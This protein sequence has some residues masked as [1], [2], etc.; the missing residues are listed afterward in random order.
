MIL[1]LVLLVVLLGGLL[2][3]W[4]TKSFDKWQKEGVPHDKPSF[5]NGTHSFLSGKKH[6]NDFALEDYKKFKMEQGH[7]VHGWF[8]MGKPALSINDPELLKQIQVKDFNHFVDRM[9]VNMAKSFLKGG[10]SDKVSDGGEKEIDS[11]SFL[12]YL[13]LNGK[14]QTFPVSL[15]ICTIKHREN[16]EKLS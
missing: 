15:E 12:D 2:Y 9:E 1:E 10:E 4:I 3:R 5:P 7:R 14:V 16:R 8:L 11:E 6:L 13:A